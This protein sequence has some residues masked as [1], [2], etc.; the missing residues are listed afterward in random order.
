MPRRRHARRFR[1]TQSHGTKRIK[2]V[3]FSLLSSEE[4]AR[5]AVVDVHECQSHKSAGA[6]PPLSARRWGPAL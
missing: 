1:F 5:M 6:A 3:T 2:K 4:A